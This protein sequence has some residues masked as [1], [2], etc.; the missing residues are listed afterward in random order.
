M[1]ARATAAGTRSRCRAPK[2]DGGRAARWEQGRARRRVTRALGL[3]RKVEVVRVPGEVVETHGVVA[4]DETG[5][6]TDSRAVKIEDS[7]SSGLN[8]RPPPTPGF[9]VTGASA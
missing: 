6:P 7:R 1:A 4:Y 8:R 5:R 2:V 9:R 3:E